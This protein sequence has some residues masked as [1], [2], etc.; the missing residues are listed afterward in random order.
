[1]KKFFY[2][3]ASVAVLALCFTSC[4]E[5]NKP[6]PEPEPEPQ[7]VVVPTIALELYGADYNTIYFYAEPSDTLLTWVASY[8]EQEDIAGKTDAQIQAMMLDELEYA[9]DYYGLDTYE[10][11]LYAG[12][13]YGYFELLT[14]GTNY[15]IVATYV[16]S[17]GNFTGAVTK[18]D[19]STWDIVEPTG[20]EENL[21]ALTATDFDDWRDYDGSWS[22]YFNDADETV[23]IGLT[24]FAEEFGGNFTIDDLDADYSYVWTEELG[25]S[26]GLQSIAVTSS[27]SSDGK[28]AN[29]AGN[30]IAYNGIKYIFTATADLA[31]LLG[32]GG[33]GDDDDDAGLPARR[34]SAKKG[35]KAPKQFAKMK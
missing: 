12:R 32:E 11:F 33:G 19:A 20:E 18:L 1:M 15:V 3:M 34:L 14:P 28:T 24:I 16:D 8:Y 31:E 17:Q 35:V 5:K 13:G 21:G 27:V 6:E 29:F 10:N 26:I 22:M 2:L 25:G 9:A 30:V 7:P 4:K 23:E